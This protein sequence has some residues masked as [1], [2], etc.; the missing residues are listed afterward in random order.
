MQRKCQPVDWFIFSGRHA[1]DR[2]QAFCRAVRHLAW[3]RDHEGRT[4]IVQFSI[5]EQQQRGKRADYQRCSH[6]QA[7]STCVSIARFITVFPAIAAVLLENRRIFLHGV[8]HEV[9]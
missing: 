3:R 2:S 6:P 4:A 5:A 9:D 8:L 1:G 7:C